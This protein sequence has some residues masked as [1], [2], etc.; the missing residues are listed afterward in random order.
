[1]I[2]VHTN[3]VF[4]TLKKGAATRIGY[5]NP[6]NGEMFTVS[7]NSGMKSGTMPQKPDNIFS[8]TK[9]KSD[10]FYNYIFDTKY[11]IDMAE[12]NRR[13]KERYSFSR[14]MESDINTMTGTDEKPGF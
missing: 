7:Y 13:Y 14:P 10:L 6:R 2:K 8:I 4:V 11:R 1:M 5:Q 9:D 3:E 12:E